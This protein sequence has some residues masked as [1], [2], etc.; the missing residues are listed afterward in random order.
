M[1]MEEGNQEGKNH[2]R[3]DE[4]KHRFYFSSFSFKNHNY[5]RW[6]DQHFI[7]NRKQPAVL[8]PKTLFFKPIARY[9]YYFE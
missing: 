2:Q 6:P 4:G 3:H 5:I 1:G 7:A 9:R 8:R